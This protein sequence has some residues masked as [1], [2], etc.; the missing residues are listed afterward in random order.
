MFKD[1]DVDPMDAVTLV[2]SYYFKAAKMGVYTKAE[3]TSGMAALGVEN[4]DDLKK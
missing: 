3:Y 1:L 4:M 2:I